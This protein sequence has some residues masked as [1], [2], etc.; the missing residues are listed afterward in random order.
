MTLPGVGRLP[1]LEGG[2][3]RDLQ[4]L[5]KHAHRCPKYRPVMLDHEAT[6]TAVTLAA[7]NRGV[8]TLILVTGALGV[9][10]MLVSPASTAADGASDV[11]GTLDS[12]RTKGGPVTYRNYASGTPGT[13]T[14]RAAPSPPP[15][16][17]F[18]HVPSLGGARRA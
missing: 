16:L 17:G 10:L 2:S 1:V 9:V 3:F 6:I 12:S 15:P 14:W 13:T 5:E 8:S 7:W 18:P 11:G 4:V